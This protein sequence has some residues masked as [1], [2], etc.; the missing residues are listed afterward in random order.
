V[1]VAFG[2]DARRDL[3]SVLFVQVAVGRAGKVE[4]AMKRVAG[5]AAATKVAAP[6][7][8]FPSGN[9]S[10]NESGIFSTTDATACPAS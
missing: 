9:S 7:A 8:P 6:T 10:T 2:Q 5:V 3:H 4:R 1:P